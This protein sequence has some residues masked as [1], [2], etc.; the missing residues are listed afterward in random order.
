MKMP[1]TRNKYQTSPY[2]NTYGS[3]DEISENAYWQGNLDDIGLTIVTGYDTCVDAANGV[4]SNLDAYE[5]EIERVCG[6]G[7]FDTLE[8]DLIN[9]YPPY[10]QIGE[11]LSDKGKG[12][13]E[14]GTVNPEYMDIRDFSDAQLSTMSSGTKLFLLFKY[15]LNDQMERTRDEMNVT[16]IESQDGGDLDEKASA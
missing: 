7:F 5:D 8:L 11:M 13:P 16:L 12:I 10:Q 6:K 9:G 2:K 1:D 14:K 15:I 3:S 4:F